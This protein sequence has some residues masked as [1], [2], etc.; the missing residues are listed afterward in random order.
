MLGYCS[1]ET[2]LSPTIPI[3]QTST[4]TTIAATQCFTKYFCFTGF[5]MVI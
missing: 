4:P 2:E 5:S 1:I 3:R